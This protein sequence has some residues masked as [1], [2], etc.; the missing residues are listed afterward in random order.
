MRDTWTKRVAT[1]LLL[2]TALTVPATAA[3]TIRAVVI[4]GYPA[5][6]L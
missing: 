2:A 3:E 4:D 1:G 6:A 5:K